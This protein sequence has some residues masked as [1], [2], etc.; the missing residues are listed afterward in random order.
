MEQSQNRVS[1]RHCSVQTVPFCLLTNISKII[2]DHQMSRFQL[3]KT[4]VCDYI[5]MFPSDLEKRRQLP[6]LIQL[7]SLETRQEVG[8]VKPTSIGAFANFIDMVL[9]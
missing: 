2:F 3:G 4:C 8:M 5:V 7:S 1:S 9:S 6:Q